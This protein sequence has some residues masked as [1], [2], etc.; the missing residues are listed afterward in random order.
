MKKVST[1]RLK[2]EVQRWPDNLLSAGVNMGMGKRLA[3][4]KVDPPAE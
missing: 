3:R 2:S 1:R 4:D